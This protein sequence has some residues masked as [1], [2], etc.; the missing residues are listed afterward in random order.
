MKQF[1]VTKVLT[2]QKT[3]KVLCHERAPVKKDKNKMI[4]TPFFRTRLFHV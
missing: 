3:N 1:H 4:N 2:V